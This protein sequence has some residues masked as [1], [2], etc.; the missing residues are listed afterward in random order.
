MPPKPELPTQ[1]RLHQH[2]SAVPL[3]KEEVA[4]ALAKSSPSSATGPDG[5]PYSVWKSVNVFNPSLLLDLL[6]P[7][8]AFGYHP[9]TLKHANGVVLDKPGKASYDT[10]ASFRIIVL[11]KTISKV[12]ERILTI[13]L[14][15]L[16]RQAGLLHPNQCGSLPGLST[17]DAVATLTHEVR[18]LQ[19][20]LLKVSTLFPEIKAGFNNVNASKLRALL[21]S[22]NIPS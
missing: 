11:L 7:L 8:V 13:R 9:T 21:L 18:T 14:T 1:G 12:L 4:A 20:P 3:T 16:A 5:V 15:S 6:A 10:P 2:A 19:I 17:S 22:R